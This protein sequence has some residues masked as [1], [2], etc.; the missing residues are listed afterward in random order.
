MKEEATD[1]LKNLIPKRNLTIRTRNSHIPIF[2]CRTDCFKYSFFPSTLRDWFNLDDDIRNSESISVFKN[3]LLLF[4]PPVQNSVFN[5][6]DPKRL[7]LLTWLRLGFSYLSE[8]RFWH[9]FENCVNPLCS[10]S[11]EA[12]DTLHCLLHYQ[13]FNQH[14]PDLM[15]SVK[16]VLDN[17]ESLSGNTKKEILL[18]GDSRL[19]NK[20]KF[21]LE[22][23]LNYIK[24]SERFSGSLFE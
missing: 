12:E 10:C 5:I 6:F 20:N 21:I 8:H 4:I 19:D 24:T 9:N 17:I 23:T 13:H 11:L 2:R 1:Y 22:A 16:S 14:R 3:R 7:K 15:N 18:Y